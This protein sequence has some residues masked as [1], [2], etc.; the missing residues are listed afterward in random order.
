[1]KKQSHYFQEARTLSY[2]LYVSEAINKISWCNDGD[3]LEWMEH[4][5]IIITSHNDARIS[6]DCY[7][8]EFVVFGIT[9]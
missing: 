1:M 3:R 6:I 2:F 4:Q 7:F 8:Q 5:E 9:G